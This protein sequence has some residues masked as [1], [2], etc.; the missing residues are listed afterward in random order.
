M[1]NNYSSFEDF[2]SKNK[3]NFDLVQNARSKLKS[4]QEL[5]VGGFALSEAEKLTFEYLNLSALVSD[6][7]FGLSS[8]VLGAKGDLKRVEG[9]Y[10]RDSKGAAAEKVK[11]VQ[12]DQSFLDANKIFNDLNDIQKYLQNKK[13]DFEAAYYHYRAISER[14]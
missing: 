10:F 2:Y 4:Y 7:M 14:K 8:S 6:L 11:T 12:A 5:A 9:M 3:D 13:T 1:F